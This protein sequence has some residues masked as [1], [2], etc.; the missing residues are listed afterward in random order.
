MEEFVDLLKRHDARG[1]VANIETQYRAKLDLLAELVSEG[2]LH[3]LRA[4]DDWAR[5]L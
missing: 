3:A 4:D 5:E 2:N 1:A